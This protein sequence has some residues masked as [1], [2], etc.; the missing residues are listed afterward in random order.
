MQNQKRLW[1]GLGIVIA[2]GL[3]GLISL[4]SGNEVDFNTQIRPILNEK[5]LRCHGGVKRNGELSLLFREEALKGGESGIPAIVPGNPGKSELMS[6]LRHHDPE[7]RMP[8]EM[9]PLTQEEIELFKTW[10]SEGAEWETHWAYIPPEKPELPSISLSNWTRNEIDHFILARLEQEELKPSSQAKP[11]IL[12]RR[13]SL[14]LTGLPPDP[15]SETLL[16]FLNDP[17]DANYEQLVDSLLASPHYGERWAAMWLDLARY[18]DSKGYEKDPHRSI[19]KYR[20][21]VIKSLNDN[22]AFD[23]FTL[24]QLAGDLLPDPTEEQLLAT[25]FHRNTMNN[26]EG[27]TEDEEFRTAAVLDRVN[28]TWTV[29]Q[30]TTMECVQC[31]SHPYDPFRQKEYYQFMAFFNNTQ[32]ADLD[33]EIPFLEHYEPKE[34]TAIREIIGWIKQHNPSAK[35]NPEA[36]LTTQIQQA[37]FPRVLPL[38][39][40]DFND[41]E[42]YGDGR[43]SNWARLPKNIPF[44]KF[45][46]KYEQLDLTN[47]ESITYR[48]NSWGDKS[49]LEL[50]LDEPDGKL[51]HGIDLYKSSKQKPGIVTGS[52]EN[53]EGKHDLFIHLVN[54]NAAT[55]DPD[56]VVYLSE[57]EFNYAN[58]SPIS[59]ALKKKQDELLNLKRKSVRTPILQERAEDNK[60][61]TQLFVRGNWLVKEDTVSA[62]MPEILGKL[63]EDVSKDRLAMARWLTSAE[64]P[65]TARVMVNRFWEQIF[66]RGIVYTSEDFG[67]QG[68]KPTHPELLDWLAVQFRDEWNWDI[69]AMLKTIVMSSTYRQS[70]KSSPELQERDPENLLFTRGPRVR[71]TAEQL[72]DQA[73]AVSGLLSRKMYGP[74]VMP[75]QPDGIWQVVYSGMQWK[76][77][78]GEDK[79]RRGIYTYWRRTSPYPS[80]TTFDSP[81]REFCMPRRI[82]TNTP[83]QALVTLNDPVFVEAAKNL[84][85]QLEEKGELEVEARIAWAFERVLMRKP[86]AHT[87]GVLTQLYQDALAEKKTE[88]ADDKTNIHAVA[89]MSESESDSTKRL[90]AWGV[91]ANALLN[92]DSFIMKE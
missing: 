34:D 44:K 30:G 17:S 41:V 55:S 53:V 81:S 77:A 45:Y 8:L 76:N 2:L 82:S 38:D 75:W 63:P 28:T 23:Q 48:F 56:G 65:L 20:D 4:F 19:W 50:R 70:S 87:L 58:I 22:K 79:F 69:K 85:M 37:I 66:G 46:L 78:E 18:A 14:D 35:V 62:D 80:M 13:L 32:D 42:L 72:R 68:I 26:T 57:M 7:Q 12:A 89:D 5:C 59:S 60:R 24:E 1:I 88:N 84:A 83:L 39:A 27:G 49:R 74:S 25:A 40:D 91:V 15:E 21:Y 64:N 47:L 51:L 29:W 43:A 86:S 33:I 9:D 36:S 67:T 71:L 52:V 31:H 54:R 16:S 61:I 92:L 11:E 6:R 73:L 90:D 3:W 10:I